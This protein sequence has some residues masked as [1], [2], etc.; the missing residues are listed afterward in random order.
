MLEQEMLQ[1][2]IDNCDAVATVRVDNSTYENI[3]KLTITSERFNKENLVDGEEYNYMYRWDFSSMIEV[4]AF[5]QRHEI[6][7]FKVFI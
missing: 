1:K 5:L 7:E 4:I 6:K 2:M 3:H